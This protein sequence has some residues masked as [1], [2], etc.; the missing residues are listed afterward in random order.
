M[1]DDEVPEMVAVQR[2][3]TALS[4][5]GGMTVAV[6]GEAAIL[7][8]RQQNGPHGEKVVRTG[9]IA[10]ALMLYLTPSFASVLVNATRPILAAL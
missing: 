3:P 1:S 4:M 7:G 5:S 9:A 6:M 10:F 2:T 8:R